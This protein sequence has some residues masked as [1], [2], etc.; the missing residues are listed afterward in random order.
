MTVKCI[1]CDE[2]INVTEDKHVLLGTYNGEEVMDESYFHFLC[3]RRH[4][5][6]KTREKAEVIV[7]HSRDIMENFMKSAEKLIKK[8]VEAVV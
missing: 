4:F 1:R 6:E 2:E 3:W 7:D 5:E 8:E